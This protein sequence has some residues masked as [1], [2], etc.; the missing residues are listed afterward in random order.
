MESE[1][2]TFTDPRDGKTYRT[3]KIGEQ[4]WMAENLN[5]ECEGSVCYDNDPK[6]A[7]KYGR[8]YDWEAA[9]KAC[10]PGWHLP[11]LKEWKDLEDFTQSY[12]I[13]GG[14]KLKAKSG[15]NDYKEKSGNGTDDYGF[16]ALPG[17]V[18]VN[19]ND[20]FIWVGNCGLWW[21]ALKKNKSSTDID[22]T[23][24]IKSSNHIRGLHWFPKAG[25]SRCFSVRCIQDKDKVSQKNSKCRRKK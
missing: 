17:G 1:T 7:K 4:V 9:N 2:E 8:L 12:P 10:P 11:S 23:W 19:P 5:F 15:W 6:N 20:S 21:V 18:S 22:Y 3:V 25:V 13:N 24:I 14:K 16:S